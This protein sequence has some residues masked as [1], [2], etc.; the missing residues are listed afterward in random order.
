M[1]KMTCGAALALAALPLA[2]CGE[3][4][5]ASRDARSGPEVRSAPP[6][7]LW[8]IVEPGTPPVDR[9]ATEGAR[10]TQAFALTWD[11]AAGRSA[12]LTGTHPTVFTAHRPGG[13]AVPPPSVRSV[14]ERLRAAGYFTTFASYDPETAAL[15][16]AFRPPPRDDPPPDADRVPLGSWDRVGADAHWR[17]REGRQP[18]FA[19]FD[20]TGAGMSTRDG[21]RNLARI[22]KE[23]DA[24][25]LAADTVVFAFAEPSLLARAGARP[26]TATDLRIPL[27]VRWPGR[28]PAGTMREDPV[29]TVDFAPTLLALGDIPAPKHLPGRAFLDASGTEAPAA[30]DP[31]A[32]VHQA[33]DDWRTSA[34]VH[35]RVDTSSGETVAAEHPAA[36]RPESYPRGGIFHVAPRIT[37]TCPAEGAVIEYTTDSYEPF[38]WKLYTGPFR[39]VDW[40][41]RF[42]CGRLGYHDSEIVKYDFD[43]EYN[44]WDY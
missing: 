11:R 35:P 8:I 44:W 22:L 20:L 12:I 21:D 28:I 40:H 13:T 31:L 26:M 24:D 33:I 15:G 41:L 6:N 36:P 9:L 27:A 1:K 38:R 5:G 7:V 30:D 25:N 34:G 16:D 14:A 42:R 4:T 23:L 19:V 18:F 29:T 32:V 3:P 39:F 37:I 17:H 10:F 43:V 2:G